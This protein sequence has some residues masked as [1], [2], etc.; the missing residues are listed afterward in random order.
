M[1]FTPYNPNQ[2]NFKEV[3]ASDLLIEKYKKEQE[4]SNPKR[5]LGEKVLDFTGGK[6]IAQGLGQRLAN[7]AISK[8]IE[9]TQVSQMKIQGDLIRVIKSP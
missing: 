2:S 3:T 7:P 6:E 9:E 8:Q 1:P 4:Q 5:T